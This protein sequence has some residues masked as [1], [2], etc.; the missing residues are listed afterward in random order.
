MNNYKIV[1]YIGDFSVL[2]GQEIKADSKEEAK[3]IAIEIV[4]NEID[5]YLYSIVEEK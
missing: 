1:G 2:T 4:K 5:K 3:K